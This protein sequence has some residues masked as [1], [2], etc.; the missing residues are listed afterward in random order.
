MEKLGRIALLNDIYGV[1]LT[2]K[3]KLLLDMFYNE[4]LSLGE[5]AGIN[6]TSRQAVFDNI[7]RSERALENYEKKLGL[8]ARNMNENLILQKLQKGYDDRD[9][10][11]IKT[12]IKLLTEEEQPEESL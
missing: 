4:D 6:K 8:L 9:W 3:Q 11:A 10:E 12:V 7:K 5:I 1:L 2:E